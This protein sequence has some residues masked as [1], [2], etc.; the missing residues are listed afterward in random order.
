M[1]TAAAARTL[2]LMRCSGL[3]I[4]TRDGKVLLT[5]TKTVGDDLVVDTR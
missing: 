4:A 1:D 2:T 3:Y 5:V